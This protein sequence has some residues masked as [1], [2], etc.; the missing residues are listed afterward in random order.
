MGVVLYFDAFA[1][2]QLI[3][4]SGGER[5]HIAEMDKIKKRKLVFYFGLIVLLVSNIC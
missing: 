2:F 1:K 4:H 5:E 3:R